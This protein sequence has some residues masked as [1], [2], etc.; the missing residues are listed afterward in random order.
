MNDKILFGLIGA[1]AGVML[2]RAWFNNQNK[3]ITSEYIEQVSGLTFGQPAPGNC[4]RHYIGSGNRI[5]R[6]YVTI[7]NQGSAV[8]EIHI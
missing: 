7:C 5:S 4:Y 2:Y 8:A 1:A 6:K 3:N